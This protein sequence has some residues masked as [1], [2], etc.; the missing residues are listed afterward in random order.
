MN[1]YTYALI[2]IIGSYFE[3]EIALSPGTVI[4]ELF[5]GDFDE[6]DWMEVLMQLQMLYGI[7]VPDE[8]TDEHDI[9][10]QEFSEELTGLAELPPESYPVF[11][12]ACLH[13]MEE[14]HEFREGFDEAA[15]D[16]EIEKLTASFEEKT[17]D[18]YGKIDA[19][20]DELD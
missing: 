9:T 2:N 6:T 19:L 5:E 12:E 11:F 13:I 1:K 8:M 14:W 16:E 10:L 3:E 15:S 20:F 18:A 4:E 17:A 7:N